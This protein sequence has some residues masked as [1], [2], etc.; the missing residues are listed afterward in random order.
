MVYT[1]LKGKSLNLHGLFESSRLASTDIGN[2]YDAIVRDENENEIEVDN[3]VALKIGESTGNGLQEVYAT[4]AGVG[5][6]IA[7]TGAPADVKTALTTEQKQ[8]YNYTNAAGKPVKAYQIQDVDV[9]KDI[10]AIASYQ[11]TDDSTDAVKVGAYVVVDGNGA[12]VAQAEKPEASTYGFIGK[13]H[14]FAV[15]TYYTLVRIEVVQNKQIA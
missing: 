11:F 10:F 9:H 15:G 1:N 8:A 4:I 7:V 13:I 6:K 3:G 2:L 12:W 14:S 5:D